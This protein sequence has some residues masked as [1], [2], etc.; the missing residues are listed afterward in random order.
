MAA[1]DS[2]RGE[3]FTHD[4]PQGPAVRGFLHRPQDGN[5]GG[6]VVTHGAGGNCDGPLLVSVAAAFSRAGVCVLR[7]N[8]PFR[9]QRPGGP[10]RPGDAADDRQGLQ[11]AAA[12]LRREVRGRIYLGGISYGGRQ[13]TMLAAEHPSVAD[14]LVL[15]SYPLHPPNAPAK[16]RTG[17]FPQLR[18]PALFIHGTRDE[19]GTPDEMQEAVK[20][21]PT[22][23][24]L[25]LMDGAGHGLAP[26]KASQ[27][28]LE[29][30]AARIVEEFRLFFA[31]R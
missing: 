1:S 22:A 25:I 28:V 31:S 5:H 10:P 27:A 12:A 30:A 19:F 17:H 14:G 18:V 21:I 23:A 13:A 8:L 7:C 20:L 16:K 11:A 15:L 26:G 29:K 3:L 9:Q 6:F 4:P 2:E 24:K